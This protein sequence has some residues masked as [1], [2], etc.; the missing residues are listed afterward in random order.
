MDHSRTPE[1]GGHWGSRWGETAMNQ[2]APF[3]RETGGENAEPGP[4]LSDAALGAGPALAESVGPLMPKMQL[5]M[6][7]SGGK[8]C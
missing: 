8:T 4:M 5:R 7:A 3:Q 1:L 6:E 2:G